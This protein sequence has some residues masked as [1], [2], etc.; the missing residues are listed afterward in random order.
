MPTAAV[1]TT[2]HCLALPCVCVV[3]ATTPRAPNQSRAAVGHGVTQELTSVAARNWRSVGCD[4]IGGLSYPD[5]VWKL[6]C[7]ESDAYS[8]TFV[9]PSI[10]Q[11][12]YER[13]AVTACGEVGLHASEGVLPCWYRGNDALDCRNWDPTVNL[14]PPN[15]AGESG[16]GCLLGFV[17]TAHKPPIGL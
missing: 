2:G 11:P 5:L 4:T 14:N 6:R 10:L 17:C 3:G 16:Q 1:D 7:F 13:H 8:T 15:Q 9:P 12:A